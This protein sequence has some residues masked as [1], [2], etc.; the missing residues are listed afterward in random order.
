LSSR[1]RCRRWSSD[2][3]PSSND[4]YF[5]MQQAMPK[6]G[7][8]ISNDFRFFEPYRTELFWHIGYIL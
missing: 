8:R 6:L 3:H 4:P 1:Y 2:Q 5:Y 7:F